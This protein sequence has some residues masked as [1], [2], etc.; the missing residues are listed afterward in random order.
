MGDL[1]MLKPFNKTVLM[2]VIGLATLSAQAQKYVMYV[3]TY[4]D[5]TSS[6]G[7]YSFNYDSKSGHFDHPALAAES[8]NPSFL[9]KSAD[10]RF[11]YAVNELSDYEGKKSGAVSAFR[12]D[13][14][15]GKLAFLN[16]VA[17]RGADPCY[18]T[19]DKTG[20]YLLVA[21]YTGGNV[22][23]FPVDKDGNVKEATGFVQHSG[24]GVNKARQEGPHA[25]WIETS[26][27]NRFALVADLGLDEL[28]VYRFDETSGNLAVNEPSYGK[29]SGGSGPRHAMFGKNGKFVYVLNE[30]KGTVNVFRYD[31]GKLSAV[32]TVDSLPE[33]FSGNNDAAELVMHPSG[34]FLY[35]SNRGEDAIVVFRVDQEKGTLQVVGRTPTQGKTPRSFAIDPTG[36]LLLAAN[37]GSDNIVVFRINQTDGK[38]T[39]T[40][41]TLAAPS[42]VCVVFVRKQ[43]R[44]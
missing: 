26:G 10:G 32:Q 6:K 33:D 41:E 27:D 28:I 9:A 25:H 7:I 18:I 21:N 11:V 30:M 31:A 15:T 19:F 29:V 43:E 20:R 5:K 2:L 37:Q 34:R 36:K 14:A 4:T 38:L 39:S 42:P 22:A 23:V 17:S 35:A 12:V 16:E 44:K 3:G 8:K 24:S 1:R 13:P 40:G